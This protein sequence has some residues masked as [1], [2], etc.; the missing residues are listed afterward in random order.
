[1]NNFF[2]PLPWNISTQEEMAKILDLV[3]QREMEKIRVE[4]MGRGGDL[5]KRRREAPLEGKKKATMAPV[6]ESRGCKK[7]KKK[8]SKNRDN[9]GVKGHFFHKSV[10]PF[11]S[12]IDH[13]RPIG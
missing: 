2:E 4:G 9:Q 10:H 3:F 1:M 12:F 6:K 11:K 7:C 5:G 8:H 13:K